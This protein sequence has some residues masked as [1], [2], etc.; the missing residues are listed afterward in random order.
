MKGEIRVIKYQ[1][2]YP[3]LNKKLSVE[4]PKAYKTA[5]IGIRLTELQERGMK[6]LKTGRP[7]S[8]GT[9]ITFI[10]LKSAEEY[11]AELKKIICDGKKIGM[12]FVREL[13]VKGCKIER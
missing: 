8:G 13:N 11:Q 9:Q 4:N 7:N 12:V 6:I 10:P 5:L 2:G 3:G 1:V